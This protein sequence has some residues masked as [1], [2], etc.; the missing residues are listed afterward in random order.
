MGYPL[1]ARWLEEAQREIQARPPEELRAAADGAQRVYQN[2][3]LPSYLRW[4]Y[5]ELPL[6]SAAGHTYPVAVFPAPAHQVN[7]PE[8]V[9][10]KPLRRQRQPDESLI[11]ASARYRA[12]ALRL[13]MEP[14]DR[15]SF[16]MRRLEVGSSIHMECELGSYLRM[17]D[18]CEEFAWELFEQAHHLTGPSTAELIAFDKRLVS[19][20]RLHKAVPNPARTGDHRSVGVAI[21]APIAYRTKNGISFLVRRRGTRSVAVDAGLFHVFPSF[22]FQPATVHLDEE[23]SVIH[24]FWR[25]YL[26]ELFN[27]PEP[28]GE[29]DWRYFYGDNR[30]E[31]LS[32]LIRDGHAHVYFTGVAVNLL[33]LRPEICL[34][35]WIDSLSWFER[36]T[37]PGNPGLR[38]SFNSEVMPVTEMASSAERAVSAIQYRRDEKAF[39]SEARL[40]PWDLV[41]VGAAAL[42]LGKRM[43]DNLGVNPSGVNAIQSVGIQSSRVVLWIQTS[44]N[45]KVDEPTPS[46]LELED[47]VANGGTDLVVDE[48]RRMFYARG[49]E[50]RFTDFSPIARKAIW[51]ALVHTGK[52][53]SYDDLAKLSCLPKDE[54]SILRKYPNAAR[55]AF[56]TMLGI[57]IVSLGKQETYY[58][59][60]NWPWTWIR[61]DQDVGQSRLL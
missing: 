61:L 8:S 31:P 56:D 5:P 43:L 57:K 15:P 59:D 44:A 1:G 25:E 49:V 7:H 27:R 28:E 12:A 46:A 37:D 39:L 3:K 9:L 11:P 21:S 36:H 35:I 40:Q 30:L 53:F 17:L 60:K 38:F 29:L 6:L 24:N 14:Y 52:S 2:A 55:T 26:E 58:V 47:L 16:T 10:T 33:N 20:G 4:R 51:L 19:R 18:T 34:L 22:M 32:S 23:H 54:K 41:P 48:P 42:W 50:H 13:G 45:G